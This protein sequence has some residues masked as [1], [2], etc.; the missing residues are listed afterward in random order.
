[1]KLRTA[2]AF[3]GNMLLQPVIHLRWRWGRQILATH[4][5]Q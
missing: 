2:Q 5:N 4:R 1:M 3:L